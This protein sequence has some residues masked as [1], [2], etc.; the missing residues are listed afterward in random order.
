MRRGRVQRRPTVIRG[1]IDGRAGREQETAASGAIALCRPVQRR[2][3]LVVTSMYVRA[4]AHQHLCD[5]RVPASSRGVQRRYAIETNG[6]YV[7]AEC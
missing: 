4:M 2:L 3:I 6:C 5:C 7:G 1:G